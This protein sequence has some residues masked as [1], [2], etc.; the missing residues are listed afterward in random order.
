MMSLPE[1]KRDAAE[2]WVYPTNYP[3]RNYQQSICQAAI[4]S[5]TM[6]VLP[7]GLGKTLIASVVMYNYHRWFPE[8]KV[9]FLAPTRPLVFQQKEAC[10]KIMGMTTGEVAHLD[11]N[12]PVGDR[13][14]LWHRRGVIF[15]TPQTFQNDLENG[16]CDATKVVCIV[17][18]EAHRATGNYAYASI[19]SMISR[20]SLNFRVLALT[21]TPGS[22]IQKIQEVC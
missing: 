4:F 18:D 6:V 5:N 8:G 9:V 15:S 19:V 22:D 12:V 7:T 16:I 2:H 14:Q 21:A 1:V 11:G 3:V 20:Y 17:F 13:E 10:H